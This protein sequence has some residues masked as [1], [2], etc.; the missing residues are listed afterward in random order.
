[1]INAAPMLAELVV[2]S[3]WLT[4][5]EVLQQALKTPQVEN[6]AEAHLRPVSVPRGPDAPSRGLAGCS[7]DAVTEAALDSPA[8]ASTRGGPELLEEG[9]RFN[10]DPPK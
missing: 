9:E 4:I 8:T 6:V 7:L 10:S 5:G 3:Y 2:P 1:M